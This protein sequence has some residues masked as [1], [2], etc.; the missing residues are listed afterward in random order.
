M[1]NPNRAERQLCHDM[2][3]ANTGSRETEFMD[4]TCCFVVSPHL[5][6]GIKPYCIALSLPADDGDGDGSNALVD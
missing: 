2:P 3:H 4:A 5:F 6:S 1:R